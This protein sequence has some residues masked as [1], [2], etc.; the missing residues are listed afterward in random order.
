LQLLFLKLYGSY[1]PYSLVIKTIKWLY[2]RRKKLKKINNLICL[3]A[4]QICT[5]T[6]PLIVRTM[7][8]YNQWRWK[9]KKKIFKVNEKIVHCYEF[10][11]MYWARSS[12]LLIIWQFNEQIIFNY[13]I[14]LYFYFFASLDMFDF[15]PVEW[16]NSFYLLVQEVICLFSIY[17]NDSPNLEH[18]SN[19]FTLIN[20]EDTYSLGIGAIFLLWGSVI[21]KAVSYRQTSK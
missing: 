15:P 1:I 14:V 8:I 18:M 13:V 17:I 3:W 21:R 2:Y 10:H 5:T 12:V 20:A 9:T 16:G 11:G 19:D 6:I 7:N 4:K